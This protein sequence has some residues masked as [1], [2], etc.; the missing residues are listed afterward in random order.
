MRM[1]ANSVLPPAVATVRAERIEYFAGIARKDESEC[2]SRLP[3]LNMR[4]R[5]SRASGLP[6][7]SRFDTSIMPDFRRSSCGFVMLPPKVPSISPKFW[8]NAIC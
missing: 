2:H 8:V 6:S 3:R 7:L 5:S 1:S 4:R